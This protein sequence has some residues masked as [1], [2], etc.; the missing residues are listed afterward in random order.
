MAE[1][2]PTTIKA[3]QYFY[4]KSY[5][6]TYYWI[7][8]FLEQWLSARIFRNDPSRVFMASSSYAFRR[9]FELTDA[10]ENYDDIEA[11]SLRF[12]FANYDPLDVGWSRDERPAANPAPLIYNGIYEG[13]TK[14]RAASVIQKIPV[15]FYFD[16]EDDARLAYDKLYFYTYNEHYYSTVIPYSQYSYYPDGNRSSG[17]NLN[18]PIVIKIPTINFNPTFK[19]KDWLQKNRIFTITANLDVRSYA[20]FPP[21]QPD[22]TEDLSGSDYVDNY[23]DGGSAYYLVD[24]VILNLSNGAYD[25]A[26]YDSV[27]S[28]PEKGTSGV[29]Y[30]DSTLKDE[31]RPIGESEVKSINKYYIW[32]EFLN[33][34]NGGY[35]SYNS[36]S[37][38]ASSVRASGTLGDG[39]VRINRLYVKEKGAT[40]GTISWNLQNPEDLSKV[41]IYVNNNVSPITLDSSAREYTLSN[42]N[43]DTTYCLY[44]FFYDKNGN[45]TKLWIELRTDKEIISAPL[46]SLV[47][48]TW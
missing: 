27:D 5:I 44:F 12:P 40:S 29:I 7:Y 14:I 46:N 47:G 35:E 28:F 48:T 37:F 21:S 2:F 10:S 13:I 6:P 31:N 24:D 45:I 9:R 36:S 22:Y 4:H 19:E 34:N 20:I 15:T 41:D 8:V 30:V 23:D 33:N 3:S 39:S 16:R 42:L 18:L 17:T 11:S 1:K 32:N 43:S 38:C 25:I 26:A